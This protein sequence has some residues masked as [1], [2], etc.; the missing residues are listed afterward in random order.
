MLKLALRITA[1][2][3]AL[4][5]PSLAPAQSYELLYDRA[6]EQNRAV[7]FGSEAT[8][9]YLEALHFQMMVLGNG[10]VEAIFAIKPR[11]AGRGD[12]DCFILKSSALFQQPAD[13]ID[14]VEKK[15][16]ESWSQ[17]KLYGVKCSGVTTSEGN[18][19]TQQNAGKDV[20]VIVSDHFVRKR[21]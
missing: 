15:A 10:Y 5:S 16:L 3:A 9:S 7:C 17:I 2:L 4:L 19:Y 14:I 8:V 11:M 13:I 12:I 6:G 20:Y 18:L 21:P 1:I